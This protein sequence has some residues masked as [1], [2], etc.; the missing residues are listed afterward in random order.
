MPVAI[1]FVLVLLGAAAFLSGCGGDER[2]PAALQLITPEEGELGDYRVRGGAEIQSGPRIDILSPTHRSSYTG[3]F[4]IE[5][6]FRAGENGHP[7]NLKSLRVIYLRAWGIDITSRLI[8]YLTPTGIKVPFAKLPNGIH[9]VE[10]YIEDTEH[11]ASRANFAVT[12]VE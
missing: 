1:R 2:E 12:I 4:P 3:G 7:P 11:N 6:L 9:E 8:E 10:I 5:V